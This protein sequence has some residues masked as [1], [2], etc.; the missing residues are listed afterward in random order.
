MIERARHILK[1]VFGYDRFI[2]LQEEVITSVLG[3]RDCLAV[4]PTG[5][6]K[7]LCYQIPALLFGGL[8]VVV[9]PLIALMKDQIDAL[10]LLGV[11]AVPLNSSLA[12]EAYRQNVGRVR[13][14][15]A[16]LL[17]VAPETLLRPQMLALLDSI[18]VSALAID[19]AHCIS[20]WGHDFRPAYRQLAIV[21]SRIPEA[22]CSAL[23]ATATPRVRKDI[24]E[25]LGFDASGEH[26][27]S[28]N[29]E[30]L[31]IRVVPKE[32]P[33]HQ[34]IDLLRRHS[35]DPGIIYCATRRQVDALCEALH[36]KG[37]SVAPYHAGL[38]DAE[39]HRSQERF[40]RDEVGVMVAT[41]AFGMGIDKSNYRKDKNGWPRYEHDFLKLLS[42]R[43]VEGKFPKEL[44]HQGCLLCGEDT[45]DR[46]HRR[47]VPEYL[48]G[49]WGDVAITHLA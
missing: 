30:N 28:F 9:S 27:A 32:N 37:F 46:C 33:L 21:R 11:P 7:S 2:S 41:V 40:V 42:D 22:V 12:P 25:T 20:K 45:P 16:K 17:Y 4:M 10:G 29:R 36:A 19:E 43:R 34:A 44:F 35:N 6:G 24:R 47:L 38:S 1:S 8:T 5:G 48:R 49:H 31:L 26:V 23:T 15:E 18:P 14:G 13:R 39:R 3:G